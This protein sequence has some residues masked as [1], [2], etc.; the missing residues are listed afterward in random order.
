MDNIFDKVSILVVG[1][2][3]YIDVWNHFFYLMNKY[4]KDRPKTYLATSELSPKYE[5]VEVIKAGKG[6]EWSKRAYS[7][8][9]QIH[10]PYVILMLEDFFITDYVNNDVVQEC[11][12]LVEKDDIKLFE[13]LLK[14]GEK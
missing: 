6:S 1:F 11:L 2:D 12:E 9:E 10:T 13:L 3:G 14:E 5:N 7:A 4:W 8:L